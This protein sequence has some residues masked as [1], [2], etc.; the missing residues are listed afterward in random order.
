MDYELNEDQRAILEA[1]GSLLERHAGPA[2]A[3]S[4]AV[5][6]AYD[7]ELD[8]ALQAAGFDGLVQGPETGA[9]EAALV[10]DAIASAPGVVAYA[11]G[12]LVLPAVLR[13]CGAAGSAESL[14]TGPLALLQ[15]GEAGPVRFGAH[16]HRALV[17]DADEARL[18]SLDPAESTPVRSNFGYPLGIPGKTLGAG[19][20][21]PAGAGRSLRNWWRVALAI[22][23]V[24]TMSGALFQTTEYLKQ[25]RQFG[26][27]IASFQAV[28][29]RLAECAIVLEGS[30]WLA[31]EAAYHG[32]PEDLAATAAAYALAAAG[33][34]FSE[35]HQ[36][37]GAIGF[38]HEHDLHV[39]TMRLQALRVE[40][41]GVSGHCRAV[42]GTRWGISP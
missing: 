20:R 8:T 40:L 4:L 31:L 42:S 1:V 17:L 29:H 28:Q 14:R 10:V 13:D 37:S 2:R 12:G 7:V 34:V 39:W 23:A 41:G 25:R 6:G 15:A 32:A 21:L 3:I 30:R 38:T 36:L 27:A 35:T 5:E 22:E 18:V 11:A 16:A 24:G 33:R 9:L 26:R 19:E